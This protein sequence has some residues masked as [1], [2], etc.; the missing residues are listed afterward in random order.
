MEVSVFV[1]KSQLGLPVL[2]CLNWVLFFK[3]CFNLVFFDKDITLI[4]LPVCHVL[5]CDFFIFL[6]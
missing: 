5:A 1:K 3:I 2:S 6:K 4:T